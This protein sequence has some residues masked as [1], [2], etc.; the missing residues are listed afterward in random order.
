MHLRAQTR[1]QRSICARLRWLDERIDQQQS[2]VRRVDAEWQ[3]ADVDAQAE[4]PEEVS[5]PARSAS[6][7]SSTPSAQGHSL[8]HRVEIMIGAELGE[9]DRRAAALQ[10]VLEDLA[11]Q[12]LR[13]T[14]NLAVQGNVVWCGVHDE[15]DRL[16][17]CESEILHQLR[18]VQRRREELRAGH[19]PECPSCGSRRIS[20]DESA[21]KTPD[22]GPQT[23]GSADGLKQRACELRQR[24]GEERERLN[25][26]LRRRT[27]LEAIQRGVVWDRSLDA[28]RYMLSELEQVLA[29][30][31]ALSE[32]D[33]N[34]AYQPM[35]DSPA[36]AAVIME[37]ASA[38]FRRLTH[39][40]FS[41][42]R[43]DHDAGTLL[44]E[45]T[46]GSTSRVTTL[47]R[48]TN[49]QAALALRL[50]IL[51]QRASVG[52]ECPALW[53][54]A[55]ADS[56]DSRLHVAAEELGH[57]AAGGQQLILFTCRE[58]VVEALQACG[59]KVHR[60]TGGMDAVPMLSAGASAPDAD[61]QMQES[62]PVT[63][64]I[65]SAED[66]PDRVGDAAFEPPESAFAQSPIETEESFKV[67]VPS[68]VTPPPL[69]RVHPAEPHWLR[70]DSPL[71]QVPSLG[72]QFARRLRVLGVNNVQDLIELDPLHKAGLLNELQIAIGEIQIWQAE[73]R[74]LVS[75]PDLTAR[76][77]QLL[78]SCGL[79]DAA[80]LAQC[81]VDELSQRIDR[82]QGGRNAWHPGMAASPRREAIARWI[83]AAR[84]VLADAIAQQVR[85][86]GSE[87]E[88]AEYSDD[89][90]RYQDAAAALPLPTS[91]EPAGTTTRFRLHPES[92]ILDAPSIGLKTARLLRRAGIQ[93][94][95][96]LLACDAVRTAA[97]L[98]H[99]RLTADVLQTWQRQS[100]LMCTVPDL[101]C[102]DAVVLVSCGIAS[103]LDLRRISPSA[104]A[105]ML[106]PLL[107]TA[108]GQRMLRGAMPPTLEDIARWTE[109]V[110]ETRVRRAA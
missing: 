37:Q 75:I 52:T 31:A 105:S 49:E 32:S 93:T 64:G 71:T 70:P 46:T 102:A 96:D 58:R 14:L 16:D 7:G 83:G 62:L 27:R 106:L 30:V 41:T 54:D 15:R 88:R 78:A 90:S 20:F 35:T 40:Q 89:R 59:A 1:R 95:A 110:E 104:L 79:N 21:S 103:P 39:G 12:R 17:R 28:L 92:P 81:N 29:G 26:L 109:T 23:G 98:R 85:T 24:L 57:A 91:G 10:E 100:V 44:A 99:R 47:S 2:V 61:V 76:D 45:D 19:T 55:L 80:D 82:L 86:P 9:L 94:V 73:A 51:C 25:E 13:H 36:A 50:A 8:A 48:G 72:F 18:G 22:P 65:G 53:D 11:T 60:L 74:L 56:D 101:R 97:R 33:V 66:E 108:D 6:E 67:E 77:A 42:L 63:T 3:S 4:K 69:V 43:L 84:G 87:G 68:S 34:L 38:S 5:I 107:E